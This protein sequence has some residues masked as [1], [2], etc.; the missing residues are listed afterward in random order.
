MAEAEWYLAQLKP[1]CAQIAKRNLEQQG[2]EVFLPLERRSRTTGRKSAVEARPYF[3]GYIFVA[4]AMRAAPARSIRST[5]GIAQLVSF[6]TAPAKVPDE[7]IDALKQHCDEEG[8][9]APMEELKIGD[10]VQLVGGPF[11][12][13]VGEIQRLAGSQR[14]WLLLERLEN[15]A[16]VSVAHASIRVLG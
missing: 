5:Q 13:L 11:A 1:N 12:D 6:G 15:A 7:L 2:F 14:V 16:P 4:A 10:R 9:F 3:P 8:I